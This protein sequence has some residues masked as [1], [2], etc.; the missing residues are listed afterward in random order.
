MNNNNSSRGI[1]TIRDTRENK[2][3]QT[4][5]FANISKVNSLNLLFKLS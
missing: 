3:V 5:K 1:Q 2:L 4:D